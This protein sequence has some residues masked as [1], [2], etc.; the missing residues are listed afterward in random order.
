MDAMA[1]ANETSRNLALLAQHD[2]ER[3]FELYALSL[4]VDLDRVNDPEVA[5][6]SPRLRSFALF[7]HAATATYLGSMLVLDT[8]GNIV[9]TQPTTCRGWDFSDREYVQAVPPDLGRKLL[10]HIDD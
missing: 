6:A 8:Q 4:Q 1:R 3:N 5:A 10:G 2:F 7:D 9:S